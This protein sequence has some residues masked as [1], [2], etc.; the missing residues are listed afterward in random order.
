MPHV[1]KKMTKVER[2]RRSQQQGK[3]QDLVIQPATPK[4][5]REAVRPFVLDS[6]GVHV[7]EVGRPS[8]FRADCLLGKRS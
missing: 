3:L 2:Q 5:Y 7:A 6:F 1:K 8:A 4:K